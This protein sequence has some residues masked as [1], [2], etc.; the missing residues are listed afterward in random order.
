MIIKILV[1]L[2]NHSG[3]S[4]QINSQRSHS[5]LRHVI[6]TVIVS[7]AG[8]DT[9]TSCV[10]VLEALL[11]IRCSIR[12]EHDL[13]PREYLCVKSDAAG[14]RNVQQVTLKYAHR[15]KIQN[16]NIMTGSHNP[17]SCNGDVISARGLVHNLLTYLLQVILV[18]S[19][20]KP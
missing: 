11:G 6:N 14:I 10:S 3:P 18:I 8:F 17:R 12:L 15:S 5:S 2:Q 13:V 20:E 4:K 7:D 16:G 9:F 1:L 19:D